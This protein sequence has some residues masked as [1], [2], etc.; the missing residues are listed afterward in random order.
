MHVQLEK[1]MYL[2]YY[3]RHWWMY[4]TI[5]SQYSEYFLRSTSCVVCEFY[6]QTAQRIQYFL[7]YCLSPP[8]LATIYRNA[9]LEFIILK[10]IYYNACMKV[11][12]N[13]RNK[14]N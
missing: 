11:I 3:S 6:L 1:F 7:R 12:N 8:N 9:T 13:K 14:T 2:F 10:N 5:E 4:F